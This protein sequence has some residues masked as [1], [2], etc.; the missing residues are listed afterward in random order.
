MNF[1][2][3]FL[4]NFH[5]KSK[6]LQNC[7]TVYINFTT[8]RDLRSEIYLVILYIS[9]LLKS[10]YNVPQRQCWATI[11]EFANTSFARNWKFEFHLAF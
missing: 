3:S 2:T 8:Q 6:I 1:K 7:N 5:C 10:S 9:L 11:I 4:K